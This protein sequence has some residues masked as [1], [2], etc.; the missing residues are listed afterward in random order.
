[1][2]VKVKRERPD[3]RRH[4]RVTAPLFVGVGGHTVRAADWSL[5]GLKVEGFPEVVPRPGEIVDLQLMLP[6]QGFDV[7]FGAKGRVV[8]ADPE[9]GMF[10]LQFTELGE[11]ERE[12]M[13]HFLEELVRGSMVEVDDTIQ[14]I[15]VP[16]TPA[17]LEPTKAAPA[18]PIA[19]APVRRVPVKTLVMSVFYGV[20][21]LG[22]LG[23]ASLLVYSNVYKLEV[24]TAVIAAPIETVKA[25]ADGR[26]NL[27]GIKAGDTVRTGDVILEVIDSHLE[28]EIELSDI[29]IRER[30]AKLSFLKRRYIDELDRLKS[31]S[32]LEMRD[33]EQSKLDM[34]AAAA[35]LKAA[36][37]QAE[38]LRSLFDKGF[39]TEQRMEE[40]EAEAIKAEKT[41]QMKRIEVATRVSLAE[42]G[43]GKRFYNGRD[44]VG[45]EA[46]VD[47]QMKLAE[48]EI[49]LAQQRHI[50]NLK[51]RDRSAVRAPFVGR[52]LQLPRP[53]Q[54]SVRRGEV[55]AVIEQQSQR[56][57]L[58]FLNQ[59][60]VARIGLGDT[61][62]IWVPA[63]GEVIEAKVTRIDRTAGFLEQHAEAQKP[64]YRWRG[65]EDRSAEVVL[66]FK[67]EEVLGNGER[68]R[69]GL[70]V[71]ILF[72]RKVQPA[73]QG[74]AER[75]KSLL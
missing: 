29:A 58:A 15:D 54:S 50:A 52:V 5:G 45:Q 41:L 3:Q 68:Y 38:R 62:Q 14:R 59:D 16:V 12:L 37:R 2:G 27:S 47:A 8:R 67:D 46:D 42:D 71:T 57:I 72:D 73:S 18:S 34:E 10:A 25:Q 36:K 13:A 51:M 43:L 31:L 4:H 65:H 48:S 75:L 69:P 66:S 7:S 9:A 33:V 63:L 70:P 64:G 6:F 23:Y 44:L 19:G 21:G 32:S 11:R 1:M 40:A 39:A 26:V 35:R 22:L 20:V 56:H 53:D 74:L 24:R 61:A 60:E 28:R 30:K 17:S 49:M 55:I